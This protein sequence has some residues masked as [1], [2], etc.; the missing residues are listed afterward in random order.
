MSLSDFTRWLYRGQRPNWIARTVNR[1]TA[2]V[3]SSGVTR[4]YLVTQSIILVSVVGF[5]V[6]SLL[7]DAAYAALD[8]RIRYGRGVG[9]DS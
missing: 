4:D 6:I 8:P 1:L 5:V 3:G 2:A 9:D 7:T